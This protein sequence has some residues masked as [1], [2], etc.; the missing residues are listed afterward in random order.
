MV[1]QVVGEV[2]GRPEGAECANEP[3]QEAAVRGEL[4]LHFRSIALFPEQPVTSKA[5]PGSLKLE[6]VPGKGTTRFQVLL[7][8]V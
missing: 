2:T 3:C 8:Y 4:I 7:T 6:E 1:K 5:N